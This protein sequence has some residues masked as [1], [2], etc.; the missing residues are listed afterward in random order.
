MDCPCL[1]PASIGGPGFITQTPCLSGPTTSTTTTTTTPEPTGACCWE[2]L[3]QIDPITFCNLTVC[4]VLT[5]EECK[6][7]TFGVWFEGE[8]CELPDPCFRCTTTTAGPTT[9][10]DVGVGACCHPTYGCNVVTEAVCNQF[11]GVYQG[12]G[13]LCTSVT[14]SG[15][16]DGTCVYY[17][18]G[19][20][21]VYLPDESTCPC[22]C[23]FIPPTVITDP[24][25]EYIY[26]GCTKL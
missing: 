18:N 20:S 7:R 19:V 21:Y 22:Q 13:T 24:P 25:Q 3:T 14:C 8:D 16:C 15:N 4:E 23:I 5:E 11:D 12:D 6:E 1:A 26:G 2:D 17:W 10:S 9:T